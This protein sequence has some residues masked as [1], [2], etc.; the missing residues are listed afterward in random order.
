M[1]HQL[2]T[3]VKGSVLAKKL[4]LPFIGNDIEISEVTAFNEIQSFSLAFTNS[5]DLEKVKT[6][7]LIIAPPNSKHITSSII[8][9]TNPRLDFANALNFI[10][11]DPGFNYVYFKAKIHSTAEIS[12]TAVIGHGVT[13]GSNT[14]IGHHVV[15]NNGVSIGNNCHIKSNSVIG[16]PGFGFERDER[17][18]PIRML[19]LGT[20]RI[21]N[22]VEIG[23]LNTVCRGT[24][25]DTIIENDVK[26]D[27]HVHIA[28]NCRIGQGS[29]ITACV[30]ISGGVEIGEFVWV[31][32]N[33]SIIQKVTLGSHCFVGIGSNVTKS[34]TP[35]TAVAGNPARTIKPKSKT[36]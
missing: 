31:G 16:E 15:I 12:H 11:I 28:H 3:P 23:S 9:S 24:L 32:P 26:T 4:G 21:G 1:G 10:K 30:E 2:N 5:Q 20:V 33:T 18:I 29:L 36:A 35:Y 34:V 27:D 13:I 7:S 19:H 25:M 22:N 6:T 17:G 8:E 14:I